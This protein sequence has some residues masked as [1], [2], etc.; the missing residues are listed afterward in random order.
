MTRI[1]RHLSV[2]CCGALAVATVA[3]GARP[4]LTPRQTKELQG[5]AR[6]L[7]PPSSLQRPSARELRPARCLRG[8][9]LLPC[10]EYFFATRGSLRYQ[11]RIALFRRSAVAHGWRVRRVESDRRLRAARIHVR[12]GRYVGWIDVGPDT[13]SCDGDPGCRP[14]AASPV[15]NGVRIV[16]LP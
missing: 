16:R 1:L 9:A 10:V 4:M 8:G 13:P 7:L 5:A 6:S 3:A 12:R 2:V 14:A 11:T 15:L